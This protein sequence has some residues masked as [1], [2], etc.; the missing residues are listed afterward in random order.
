MPA[1]MTNVNPPANNRRCVLN[2]L[3]KWK[4]PGYDEDLKSKAMMKAIKCDTTVKELVSMI[5]GDHTLH[6]PTFLTLVTNLE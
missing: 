4:Y 2:F 6:D 3:S 1:P 5:D